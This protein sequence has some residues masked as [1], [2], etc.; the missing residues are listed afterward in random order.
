MEIEKW[1]SK[2]WGELTEGNMR[3][4]LEAEGYSVSRFVYPSRTVFPDHSHSFDKMDAVVSGR[5]KIEA[6]GQVFVLE[7]GDMIAVPAGTVHNAKVLGAEPVI[8]LD[9][10]RVIKK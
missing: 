5:F 8:S 7:A 3:K 1:D 9:A 2:R 4:K 6:N 10:T